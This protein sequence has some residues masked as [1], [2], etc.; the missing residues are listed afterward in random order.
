MPLGKESS[1]TSATK[2]D[3]RRA[4]HSYSPLRPSRLSQSLSPQDMDP[5][6]DLSTVVGSGDHL[7][8]HPIRSRSLD[9]Q[10]K[11]IPDLSL[12]SHA[13]T[14]S[15]P[16][17]VD[18]STNLPRKLKLFQKYDTYTREHLHAMVDVISSQGTP[19]PTKGS[20]E[21]R[22]LRRRAEFKHVRDSSDA[23][24]RSSSKSGEN[25]T[26]SFLGEEH[27]P[28]E[29][30][31]FSESSW[32]ESHRRASKKIRLSEECSSEVS[33]SEGSCQAAPK[34]DTPESLGFRERK[35][36]PNS[37]DHRRSW[38]DIGQ[39][40]LRRIRENEGMSMMSVSEGTVTSGQSCSSPSYSVSCLTGMR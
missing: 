14:F 29:R 26:I 16:S 9:C 32:G 24:S 10:R 21:R 13:F 1:P 28:S 8:A 6:T 30:D 22:R 5:D 18:H 27:S 36:P 17:M 38:G 37:I 31:G 11:Y 12:Q 7:Q 2:V 34:V 19:V 25:V 35:H 4:S 33:G 3:T 39:D 23:R 15:P 20:V 40:A